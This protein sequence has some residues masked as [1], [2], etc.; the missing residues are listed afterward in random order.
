MSWTKYTDV[1]S[2]VVSGFLHPWDVRENLGGNVVDSGRALIRS[3]GENS[4]DVFVNL[5]RLVD[6]VATMFAPERHQKNVCMYVPTCNYK[7][8]IITNVIKTRTFLPNENTQNL[9][10]VVITKMFLKLH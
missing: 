3:E 9:S 4:L 6:L 7:L 10:S 1:Q 2:L 5:N 8:K